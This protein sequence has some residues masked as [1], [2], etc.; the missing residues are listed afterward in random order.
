MIQ[1]TLRL[2]ILQTNL[3]WNDVKANLSDFERQIDEVT[4]QVD[5]FVL[6]EMF[7]TGFCMQPE[8]VS[9]TAGEESL[10]WLIKQ[11]RRRQAGFCGSVLYRRQDGTFVNRMF[12][13]DSN[14]SLFHY[15]KWHRFAMAGEH[16]AYAEGSR[17]PVIALFRG[18]KILLQVC[19]DLRFP[20]FSRN[21][22]DGYDAVIYSANWPMKR[23]LHWRTLLQARAIENQAYC[24]GVNRI[25]TDQNGYEFKGDSLVFD[26]QGEAQ[27]DMLSNAG[28]G[29]VELKHEELLETRKRLPFL[30]DADSFR[31]HD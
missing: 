12:L 28:F 10:E 8:E 27:L 24:I 4:E 25:G 11:A 29:L 18:W 21:K 20:V 16:H 22:A 26:L 19:Y 1:P 17:R 2:G 31:L 23:R 7:S 30:A 9:A 6:P 15:D 3:I 14:G 13:V 5:L